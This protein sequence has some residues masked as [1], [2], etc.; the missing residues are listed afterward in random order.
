MS[1]L[2][3]SLRDQ[4]PAS[5]AYHHHTG[6]TC[7]QCCTGM[8]CSCPYPKEARHKAVMLVIH[9]RLII[10]DVDI[11]LGQHLPVQA[12]MVHGYFSCCC[13]W[14]FEPC[15]QP[16]DRARPDCLPGLSAG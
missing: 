13:W 15:L 2:S 16:R 10:I 9:I 1:H 4:A 11:V 8:Q 14:L 6:N 12:G 3:L 5:E 7:V